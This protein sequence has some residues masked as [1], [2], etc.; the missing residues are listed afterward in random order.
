[1]HHGKNAIPNRF[2]FHMQESV[3]LYHGGA[4]RNITNIY[5]HDTHTLKSCSQEFY[6]LFQH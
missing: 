6:H 1:M 5:I 2:A 3:S 4:F